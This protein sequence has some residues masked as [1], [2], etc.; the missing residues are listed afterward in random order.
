MLRLYTIIITQSTS[1]HH[2]DTKS[3][4]CLSLAQAEGRATALLRLYRLTKPG[5]DRWDR[6]T[7]MT[8][9]DR[10][11]LPVVVAYGN[12]YGTQWTERDHGWVE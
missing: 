7:V 11:L 9:R 12:N 8:R 10:S 4:K 6:W 5:A 3:A 2:R 1:T